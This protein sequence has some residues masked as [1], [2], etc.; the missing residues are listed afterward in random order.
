VDAELLVDVL[1]VLADGARRNPDRLG[2]LGIR[3]PG[4]DE[5]EDLALAAGERRR[6]PLLLEE[7][8]AADQVDE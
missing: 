7:Q 3:L 1:E 5:L 8:R 6:D 4:R 2:D